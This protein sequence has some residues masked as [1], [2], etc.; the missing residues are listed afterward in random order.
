MSHRVRRLKI[1]AGQIVFRPGDACPG[2]VELQSGTIRVSLTAANGRELVLYRVGPGDMC[3]QT[4]ACLTQ[5]QS[6]SAEGVAETDLT[7]VLVPPDEFSDRM[8]T[9]AGFRHDVLAA[10]ARRFAE[11]E[12]LV[13]EVALT[14][15][16]TRLAKCLLRLADQNGHVTASH[17][18]LAHETASGRAVVSR[19]MAELARLGIVAQHRGGIDIIKPKE[20]TRIA[21][22]E[23]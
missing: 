8:D 15:F 19:H 16:E 14:G 4:F 6:Y 11:Y 5:G 22:G 9:E 1:P 7:G 17:Q 2:L 20:L 12:R 3:L 21:A 18:S 23:R 13:E 10:V